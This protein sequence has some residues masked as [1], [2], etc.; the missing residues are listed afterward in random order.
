MTCLLRQKASQVLRGVVTLSMP[1]IP[2]AAWGSL[3]TPFFRKI[4]FYIHK[5][6][7]RIL[8]R[9]PIM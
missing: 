6:K 3:Q 4:V 1:R 8:Q 9:K 2:P 5:I 7:Y